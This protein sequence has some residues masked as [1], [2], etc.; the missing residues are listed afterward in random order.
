MPAADRIHA[1]HDQLG[2]QKRFHA[3]GSCLCGAVVVEVRSK[4]V[5]SRYCHCSVCRRFFGSPVNLSALFPVP[6]V[7]VCSSNGSAAKLTSFLTAKVER[8]RCELCGSP[9]VTYFPSRAK[10]RAVILPVQTILGA[11]KTLPNELLPTC[12]ICYADRLVDAS[13]SLRKHDH[14]PT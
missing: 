5:W 3:R 14:V 4:P 6:S 9:V 1:L 10:P 12:H 13:D 7:R 11:S 2:Q 8:C